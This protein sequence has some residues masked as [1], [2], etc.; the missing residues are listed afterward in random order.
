MTPSLAEACFAVGHV[1]DT[2]LDFSS[3]CLFWGAREGLSFDMISS[4]EE[5]S[6]CCTET[7]NCLSKTAVIQDRPTDTG[8]RA[9]GFLD[10]EG[11]HGLGWQEV[12]CS[13]PSSA[14][15]RQAKTEDD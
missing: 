8:S 14:V 13:V 5:S 1:K 4:A 11:C 6:T 15:C 7:E 3:A 9:I 10:A 2:H 12:H